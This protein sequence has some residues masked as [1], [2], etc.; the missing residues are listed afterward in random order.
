MNRIGGVI[1]NKL[2]RSRTNK[3]IAGVCGGL[4][5]YF[6]ID[7]TI[8]RIATVLLGFMSFGTF[9]IA[10]IACVVIIPEEDGVIYQDDKN[11]RYSENTPLFIGG[12]LILLGTYLLAKVIFPWFNFRIRQLFRF[13]PVLLILLG[14]Y[15]LFN[16]N[17]R[18]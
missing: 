4:G 17:D 6:N 10:Y 12:G 16:R 14:I 9:I 7:P 1:V 8:V 3:M 11:N 15:I 2:K 5:E 13:W 18:S